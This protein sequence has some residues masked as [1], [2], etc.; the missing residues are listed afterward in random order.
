MTR[1]FRLVTR[2]DR[3]ARLDQ[4]G[5]VVARAKPPGPGPHER[6]S[7]GAHD[8]LAL[9]VASRGTQTYLVTKCAFWDCQGAFTQV[10]GPLLLVHSN[11]GNR[12]R[13][14]AREGGALSLTRLADWSRF[15][16]AQRCSASP[17]PLTSN[18]A[19]KT[20][21]TLRRPGPDR[22]GP[23]SLIRNEPAPLLSASLARPRSASRIGVGPDWSTS[24][25]RLQWRCL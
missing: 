5:W 14:A 21:R 17:A 12:P 16:V 7:Y 8:P 4:N 10:T 13:R 2:A 11:W 3:L 9:A 1:S 20:R 25:R 19:L 23:H 6:D 18:L 22:R 15:G 24:R